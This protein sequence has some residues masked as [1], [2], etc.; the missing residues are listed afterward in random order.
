[1]SD[2]E[3][4]AEW[5][6]AHSYLCSCGAGA[7]GRGRDDRCTQLRS[8]IATAIAQARQEEREWWLNACEDDVPCIT[9]GRPRGSCKHESFI[10]CLLDAEALRRDAG[11]EGARG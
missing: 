8:R 11:G 3:R 5:F 7:Q 1:M 6:D 2:E 9:A 4:R 10:A